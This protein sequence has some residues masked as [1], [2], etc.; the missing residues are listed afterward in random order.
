MFSGY[1]VTLLDFVHYSKH[2]LYITRN[3]CAFFNLLYPLIFYIEP[4][5]AYMESLHKFRYIRTQFLHFGL[6][7]LWLIL[8]RAVSPVINSIKDLKVGSQAQVRHSHF[9][10]CVYQLMTDNLFGCI[11]K[12]HLLDNSNN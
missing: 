10:L 8:N 12:S 9:R 1:F 3:R 5:D 11:L 6:F 2:C 4:Q 7:V